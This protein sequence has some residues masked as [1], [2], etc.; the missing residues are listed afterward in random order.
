M[1]LVDPKELF[2]R[3]KDPALRKMLRRA[4]HEEI[5]PLPRSQR[6]ECGKERCAL[7]VEWDHD[8]HKP[9]KRCKR[10]GG[11]KARF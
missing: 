8:A 2:R 11:A 10:H 4:Y 6:P 1:P 3:L 5:T 9:G 7:P